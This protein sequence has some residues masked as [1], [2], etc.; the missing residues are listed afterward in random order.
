MLKPK[1]GT[2]C[3]K[4]GAETEITQIASLV[5]SILS[6]IQLTIRNTKHTSQSIK[7]FCK[8]AWTGIHAFDSSKRYTIS[9]VVKFSKSYHIPRFFSRDTYSF[10]NL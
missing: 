8:E 3:P 2:E 7:D 9:L 4:Y 1:K 10:K 6:S 5:P